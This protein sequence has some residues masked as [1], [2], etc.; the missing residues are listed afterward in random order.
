MLSLQFCFNCSLQQLQPF[1]LFAIIFL[2]SALSPGLLYQR[3][4]THSVEENWCLDGCWMVYIQYDR[5]HRQ[6][7]G[8]Q[9]FPE[10]FLINA[11]SID[12]KQR[13]NLT[14]HLEGLGSFLRGRKG[15]F[16]SVPIYWKDI[17]FL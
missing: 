16:R 4:P 11:L 5:P 12:I 13:F 10:T 14:Q 15:S 1:G 17:M 8:T 2:A 6:L 7:R 3:S 9:S